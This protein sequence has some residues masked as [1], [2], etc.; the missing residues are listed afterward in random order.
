MTNLRIDGYGGSLFNRSRFA[1]E[2]VKA[3]RKTVSG[4]F[5]LGFRM[6]FENAGLETG[7]D[8]DENIQI[9]KWLLEDGINYIHISL[10]LYFAK[11]EALPFHTPYSAAHLKN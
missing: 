3:C 9:C 11:G 5:V 1:R 8:I 10:P 6:S 4:D 2:V 7:L